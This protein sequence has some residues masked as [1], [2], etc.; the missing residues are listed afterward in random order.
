MWG[1]HTESVDAT[2]TRQRD[3]GVEAGE[4]GESVLVGRNFKGLREIEGLRPGRC[5]AVEAVLNTAGNL[6]HAIITLWPIM[7]HTLGMKRACGSVLSK[8]VHRRQSFTIMRFGNFNWSVGS[9]RQ[10]QPRL[11]R[12]NREILAKEDRNP[13]SEMCVYRRSWYV[14]S[15]KRSR[16][17]KR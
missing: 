7:E 4:M 14:F 5:P 17:S 16:G 3:L 15:R 1:H 13:R 12:S 11:F 2:S 9:P 8:L 6:R 10:R